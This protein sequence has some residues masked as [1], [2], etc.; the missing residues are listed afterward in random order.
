MRPTEIPGQ[1]GNDG[2]SNSRKGLSEPFEGEADAG[3][4]VGFSYPDD[5]VCDSESAG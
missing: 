5:D 3:D 2:R 4:R 1:A